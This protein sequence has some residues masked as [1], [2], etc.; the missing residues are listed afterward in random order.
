[1]MKWTKNGVASTLQMD[2]PKLVQKRHN[3]SSACEVQDAVDR[4]LFP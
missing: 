3:G 2:R 1:M 4:V